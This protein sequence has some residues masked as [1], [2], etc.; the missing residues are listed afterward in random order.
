MKEEYYGESTESTK[1]E[2]KS[3]SKRTTNTK[4][5]QKD[6][7]DFLKERYTQVRQIHLQAAE[8]HIIVFLK[9]HDCSVMDE[10][11]L[12]YVIDKENRQRNATIFGLIENDEQCETKYDSKKDRESQSLNWSRSR[13]RSPKTMSH[14]LY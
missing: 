4:V 9:E 1:E 6:C 13:S 2:E 12:T 11:A 3:K 5:F 8:K 10:T 7:L 14:I